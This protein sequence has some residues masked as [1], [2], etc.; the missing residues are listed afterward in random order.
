MKDLLRDTRMQRL[1]V[2]NTLGSI[3]SGVT[4][5][6]VPWTLVHRAHGSELFRWVTI[7]TTLVLFILMP[8]YGAWV[9]RSSRKVM[10]LIS[11]CFGF[12]A[13]FSMAV[14]AL[15]LGRVE[16]WQLVVT[17]FCGML[18][19]TLHYP[20]KF[21][22][23]QQLFARSQYQ[24]LIGLLEIQGQT[25]MMAAAALGSY[26]VDRGVGLSTILF[27]DAATY[28]TSFIIQ[29]T[30]P[31]RATHLES[32]SA[33]PKKS[34]VW[35]SVG[36]GW[37]WLRARPQLTIFLTCSLMPFIIVMAANYL[38]PI[39]V[40]QTLHAEAK[41]FGG[42]EMTFALGAITAG[43]LL[44]QL[45]ARHSAYRTISA[46]ILVFIFGL[47]VVIFLPFA[48]C[49]FLASI[50]LGFGNA[51]CRVAR[52]AFVLHVVPNEVMGRVSVFYNVFDRLMRTAL[53]AALGIIDLY[54]PQAGFLLL[55]A[56]LLAS[57]IGVMRTRS[58]LNTPVDT[59]ISPPAAA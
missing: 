26:L 28:A 50:L 40:T 48:P 58:S 51:G 38:F 5:F 4:I 6:A 34:G 20:A 9:D 45:I 39:Y 16:T 18:Y 15:T 54:G 41:V 23:I 27:F 3:G 13:T 30:L 21:A 37:G 59:L 36:E 42:G 31:Y 2:A 35:R 19:Y 1:V 22:L 46:T 52:S 7:G 17:Y 12:L 55:L 53:V 43:A 57:Y 8:Y 29:S 25:A 11:E 49:Y 44:P 32:P 14:T 47:L 56:V 10:L 24:S 33:A